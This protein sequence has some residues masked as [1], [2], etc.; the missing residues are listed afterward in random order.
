M[1]YPFGS[2]NRPDT[3]LHLRDSKSSLASRNTAT[4][5]LLISTVV[6]VPRSC[7]KPGMGRSLVLL[8]PNEKRQ[9]VLV[10]QMIQ[11]Y[12]F[13]C[14]QPEIP[15]QVHSIAAQIL[16]QRCRPGALRTTGENSTNET[17]T[18]A[19]LRICAPRFELVTVTC[20]RFQQICTSIRIPRIKHSHIKMLL[21][22]F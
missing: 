5:Q 11:R 3:H 21:F 2:Q 10:T 19:S 8:S 17:P 1:Q 12:N 15:Q 14:S 16:F 22:P 18:L 7:V 13:A 9:F 6:S 20:T 4:P